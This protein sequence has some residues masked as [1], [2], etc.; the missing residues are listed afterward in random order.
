M[1]DSRLTERRLAVTTSWGLFGSFG[2]CLICTGFGAPSLAAGLSGFALMIAGFVSNVIINRI[3]GSGFTEGEVALGL[4]AYAV[5]L[6]TFSLSWIL[7]HFRFMQ[8]VIGISGF[9]ALAVCFLF[10]TVSSHG[11]R[12][13]LELLDELR[14]L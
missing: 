1:D 9:A 11:V 12:G 4:G 5:A 7:L 14:K 8:I 10:Y 13:S 3:F 2:V 6:L